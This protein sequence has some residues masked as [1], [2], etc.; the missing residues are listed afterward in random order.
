MMSRHIRSATV[1]AGAI[2]LA[3]AL[4]PVRAEAHLNSTGLGPAYDGAVH[5]LLSPEDLV[6]AFAL[7]LLAGLRGATCGRLTLFALPAA[8][9]TGGLAGMTAAHSSGATATVV[10][11]VLLGTLVA[12]D[13]RLSVRMLTALAVSV[14]LAHGFVNGAGMGPFG[15]GVQ[16]LFGLA[17]ALFV[18]TTLVVAFVVQLRQPWSRIAVRVLGSWIAASG[19]LMLGWAMHT[20]R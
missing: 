1:T 4:C 9:L 2:V 13:A 16:A 17:S 18:L 14:G 7:A 10:S 5:L 8:W 19:L 12:I 6:S 3:M 15:V 20:T 11:F